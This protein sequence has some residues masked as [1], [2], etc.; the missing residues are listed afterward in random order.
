M[1]DLSIDQGGR[2]MM[3]AVLTIEDIRDSMG[4]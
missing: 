2:I 4:Y 3:D 1:S